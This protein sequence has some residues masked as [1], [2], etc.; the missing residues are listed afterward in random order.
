MIYSLAFLPCLCS[1]FIDIYQTDRLPFVCGG[2]YFEKGGLGCFGDDVMN[3]F[4]Y[5]YEPGIEKP[6]HLS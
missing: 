5:K 6:F 1:Y 3:E 2:N 4:C